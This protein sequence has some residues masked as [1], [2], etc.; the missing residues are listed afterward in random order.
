MGRRSFNKTA[1]RWGIFS[2]VL[3]QAL[4]WTGCPDPTTEVEYRDREVV[5]NVPVPYGIRIETAADLAKIGLDP[6]FPAYGEY[7]LGNDID[8]ADWKPEPS[9]ADP[10]PA[11]YRWKAIGNTCRECG[12]PLVPVEINYVNYPVRCVNEACGLYNLYQEP[13]TGTLHGNGKKISGLVLSGGTDEYQWPVYIGLFG[14]VQ[15]AYIHDLAVEL[16]NT[17]EEPVVSTGD[18]D[19]PATAMYVGALAGYAKNSRIE[20]IS[21]SGNPGLSVTLSRANNY[22]GGAVAYATITTLSRINAAISMSTRETGD[23]V[24]QLHSVGGIVGNLHTTGEVSESTMQGDLAAEFIHGG[25]KSVGGI[26]NLEVSGTTFKKNKAVLGAVTIHSKRET[27]IGTIIRAGGIAGFATAIQDC[28]AEFTTL[29]LDVEDPTITTL[30]AGGLAGSATTITN[31]RARFDKITVKD[32]SSSATGIISVGGLAGNANTSS[33]IT[34]SYLEG[35]T[36]EVAGEGANEPSFYV[37]GLT[38]QGTVSRSRIGYGIA[39]SLETKS[40]GVSSIGGLTGNGG[41][42]YSFIGAKDSPAK[43]TVTTDSSSAS[44]RAMY[45]GGISGQAAPSIALPFQY[46]YAFC[47]VSLEIGG[48]AATTSAAGGLAGYLSGNG[49]VTQNYAAGTVRLVNNSTAAAGT[50][51]AGGIAGYIAV[52]TTISSCAALNGEVRIEGDNTDATKNRRRIA[53]RADGNGVGTFTNNITTVAATEDYTPENGANTGDG[54]FKESPL[55]PADFGSGGLQWVFDVWEWDNG[56][57]VLKTQ[58]FQD[59]A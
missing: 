17:A 50:D 27:G 22:V 10:D 35:G 47:D 41:A 55:G 44:T 30:Y 25:A 5:E 33:S 11:P 56:Y 38:G 3:V 57:P 6:E 14:Y 36:I 59:E 16:A 24:S 54:L 21:V 4:V 34:R 31:S 43:V 37:G 58:V 2:A 1:G 7:Y 23:V 18:A 13:F 48:S 20:G 51:Y 52:A 49:P 45:V 26:G 39:I 40:H 28:A 53:A 8:L 12:G 46:N 29:D 19:D 9:E 15:G 42:S 32:K